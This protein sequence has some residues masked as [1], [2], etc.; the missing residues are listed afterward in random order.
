MKMQTSLEFILLLSA[1]ALFSV[2]I[3]SQYLHLQNAQKAAYGTLDNQSLYAGEPVNAVVNYSDGIS[4]TPIIANTSYVGKSN[5]LELVLSYPQ[6][7]SFTSLKLVSSPNASILP[8]S[9]AN[10]QYSP[11]EV[12][13]FTYIPAS[14]GELRISA[15]GVLK[16]ANSSL[17]ITATSYTYAMPQNASRNGSSGNS[18]VAEITG[19][20]ESILYPISTLDRIGTVTTWS[21]CAYHDFWGNREPEPA[22]CGGNTWGVIYFDNNCNQFWQ[23]GNDRYI[24]F[25]RNMSNDAAS[26]LEPQQSYSYNAVLSI[27]N[28]TLSLTAP[29]SDAMKGIALYN[30]SG[31]VEGNAIVESVYTG[32]VLPPPYS[33]VAV[34][35]KLGNTTAVN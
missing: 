6:S 20:N 30:G 13:T 31:G 33:T 25:K 8:P 1:V 16:D 5:N 17:N 4:M 3:L 10:L 27:G 34:L 7:Y 23:G 32:Q 29:F 14:A 24:C 22:Q 18:F 26:A 15:Y 19:R 12:L 21:H 9:L 35:D 28:S 11:I 2:F